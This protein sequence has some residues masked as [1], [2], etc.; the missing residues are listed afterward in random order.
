MDKK[1]THLIFGISSL[2]T[3]IA[4]LL[5]SNPRF[6]SSNVFAENAQNSNNYQIVIRKENVQEG[7]A[8]SIGYFSYRNYSYH[9]VT[10]TGFDFDGD[11]QV[12]YR[13][14]EGH[15]SMGEYILDAESDLDLYFEMDFTLRNINSPINVVISGTFVN[16]DDDMLN[17]LTFNDFAEYEDGSYSLSID[18]EN[19]NF[20]SILIEQVTINYSC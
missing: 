12:W 7:N 10:S 11:Y 6:G 17:E 14:N 1:K 15:V 4:T 9:V 18:T 19:R 13:F 3:V 8:S 20:K 5:I 16:E 2:C